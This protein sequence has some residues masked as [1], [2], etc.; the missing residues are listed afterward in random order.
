MKKR[1]RKF[2]FRQYIKNGKAVLLLGTAV[3]LIGLVPGKKKR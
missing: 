2:C 3:L 1:Q